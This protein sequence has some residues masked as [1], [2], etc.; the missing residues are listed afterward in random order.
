MALDESS[1]K[2]LQ[3]IAHAVGERSVRLRR[4]SVRTAGGIGSAN[5]DMSSDKQGERPC[6]RK[7]KVSCA[8]FIGAG[9]RG[10]HGQA[11]M[12]S[13]WET[14][15]YSCTEQRCDGG[16]EK[17]RAAGD[18]LSRFKRVAKS[19]RQIRRINRET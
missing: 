15:Q 10:P 9:R 13:R 16:T 17:V 18:W 11:E 19:F 14:G 12:R 6:R 8:T 7:P 5:A 1:G 2:R 3:G 4:R